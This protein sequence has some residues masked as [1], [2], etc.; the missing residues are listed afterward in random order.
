MA[1]TMAGAYDDPPQGS[2]LSGSDLVY[3][4]GQ[5]PPLPR[6]VRRVSAAALVVAGP[7]HAAP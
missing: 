4:L 3:R 2:S 6:P 5:T 1:E 7:E